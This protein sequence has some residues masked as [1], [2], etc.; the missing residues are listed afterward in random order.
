MQDPFDPYQQWL[1]IP[2]SEQ[3][4][5]HYRLLGIAPLENDS[6]V[7]LR[8]IEERTA[9]V[10]ACA[11][12]QHAD[13]LEDLLE[14]L[15]TAKHLLLNPTFKQQY[16]LMLRQHS[17]PAYRVGYPASGVVAP[18]PVQPSAQGPVHTPSPVTPGAGGPLDPPV[19]VTDA[20]PASAARPRVAGAAGA[21]GAASNGGEQKNAAMQP[22][23]IGAIVGGAV[24]LGIL[25]LVIASSGP[26]DE[27]A[28]QGDRPAS[29]GSS[30]RSR[31]STKGRSSRTKPPRRDSSSRSSP[32]WRG[33]TPPPLGSRTMA[34][35]MEQ[36][37]NAPPDTRSTTGLL[38]AARMAMADRQLEAARHHVEAA[39]TGA[40]SSTERAEVQRVQKLL[41]ALGAFWKAVREQAARLHAA[42]EVVVGQTRAIVVEVDRSRLIM[43]VAGKLRIYNLP[44]D[45][46][47]PLAVALAQRHVGNDSPAANLRIGAFLAIDAKGDRQEARRRWDNAGAE[48]KALLPELELA[49]PVKKNGPGGR[50]PSPVMDVAGDWSSGPG[51]GPKRPGP[52]KK[53]PVP[54]AAAL[55]TA[56]LQVREV[57]KGEFAGARNNKDGK[58][59][60]AKK[61]YTAAEETKDDTAVRYFMYQVARDTAVELGD[62]ESFFWAI[63]RMDHFYQID[64]IGMKADMLAKAWREQTES[65]Q[66]RAVYE[67]SKH[68][69]DEAMKAKHYKAA[70][71]VVRVA[72]AGA[73][74]GRDHALVRELEEKTREIDKNTR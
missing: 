47:R 61:M 64:A 29:R 2:P 6:A 10:R 45:L 14:D 51:K 48:G 55:A 35:L 70:G 17:E 1:G 54:D 58:V 65:E 36:D 46:P 32:S 33:G 8:A 59:A 38:K 69:L 28:S 56:E 15:A 31:S 13:A 4:P 5:D 20:G 42:E 72:I 67:Y 66:R 41:D 21:T 43:K 53:L 40:R 30:D 27:T 74:A 18:A 22:A 26:G 7:I 3:P 39:A 23:L 71:R 73:K 63:G 11:G 50:T 34:D 44:G 68:L 16:D 52:P 57:F 9:Y 24:L 62:P 19:I 37:D 60:L 12:D 49:G 25:V